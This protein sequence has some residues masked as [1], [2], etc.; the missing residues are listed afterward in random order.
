MSNKPVLC[1]Q[2]NKE[3]QLRLLEER[4]VADYF[5]LIERNKKYLHMWIDMEAYEGSLE[6]LRAY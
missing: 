1:I 5:A 6:T 3:T 2:V 4:H